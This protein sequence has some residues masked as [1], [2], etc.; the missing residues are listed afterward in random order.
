MKATPSNAFRLQWFYQPIQPLS[1]MKIMMEWWDFI[2]VHKEKV[3]LI[4][5]TKTTL[6]IYTTLQQHYTIWSRPKIPTFYVWT[7][8]IELLTKTYEQNTE[9]RWIELRLKNQLPEPFISRIHG[10]Y[11]SW[12]ERNITIEGNKIVQAFM[13]FATV[14]L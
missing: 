7:M 2:K 9:I 6:Q 13:S 14:I 3:D 12:Y 5:T 11:V 8:V 10:F 1:S 4:C